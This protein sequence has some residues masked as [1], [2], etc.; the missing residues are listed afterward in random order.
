MLS[1]FN[2][3]ESYFKGILKKLSIIIIQYNMEIFLCKSSDHQ[4]V[5]SNYKL[6]C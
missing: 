2:R 3:L 5:V 1:C 4:S 6:S